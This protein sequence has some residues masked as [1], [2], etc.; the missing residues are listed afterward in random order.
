MDTNLESEI[1]FIK[2]IMQDSRRSALDSGK[3]YILWGVL[4][5]FACLVNYF[6]YKSGSEISPNYFWLS[7]IVTGW[8]VSIY[9]GYKDSRKRKNTSLG[10]K[11]IS[12]V[13]TACGI[14]AIVITIAGQVSDSISGASIC[15]L[16]TTI[17]G[18][19]Y[20]VAGAV[21]SDKML[22]TLSFAWWAAASW[23]FF[24]KGIEV[25]LVYG[26]FL[27]LFQV[28]PGFVLNNK[29]KKE[30]LLKVE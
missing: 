13:W 24:I 28:I 19:G 25:L 7:F 20:F 11:V 22:V 21:Y 30:L 4:I 1:L 14:S 12:A 17:F 2:K 26:L 16:I 15:A 18:V 9:W 23:M 10:K 27:L 3:Y 5:G 6:L 8:I 29:W